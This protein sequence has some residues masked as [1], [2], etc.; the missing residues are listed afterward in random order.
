M[1]IHLCL[2][3]HTLE[4]KTKIPAPE[5]R[6]GNTVCLS[7]CVC[8]RVRGTQTTLKKHNKCI[9]AIVY[10]KMITAVEKRKKTIKVSK[11]GNLGKE[12]M[13]GV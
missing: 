6:A 13:V 5:E 8:M 7:T 1:C 4:H 10:Y 3:L 11:F 9:P 2:S 12:K